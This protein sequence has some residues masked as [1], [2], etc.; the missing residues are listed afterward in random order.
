MLFLCSIRPNEEGLGQLLSLNLLPIK[1]STSTNHPADNQDSDQEP[2]VSRNPHDNIV[3][4]HPMT[5][6]QPSPQFISP[7]STLA[8]Q[9]SRDLAV[10]S[11]QENPSLPGNAVTN[12]SLLTF[13]AKK[14][15][16][17]NDGL[18]SILDGSPL[19]GPKFGGR[20]RSSRIRRQSLRQYYGCSVNSPNLT[21]VPGELINVRRSP[22]LAGTLSN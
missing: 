15:Q 17:T 21:E 5:G 2:S 3:P 8:Q 6:P 20:K 12:S 7:T 1:E 4:S 13:A 16:S 22:R 10:K 11:P 9:F 18:N 19:V 14:Y